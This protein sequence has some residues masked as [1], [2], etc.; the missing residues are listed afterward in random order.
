MS[1]YVGIVRSISVAAGM[2]AEHP[3]SRDRESVPAFGS[4]TEICELR[5]SSRWILVIKQAMHA[6]EPGCTNPSIIRQNPDS[7]YNAIQETIHQHKRN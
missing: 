4:I 6:R 3:V 5:T 7:T 1:S 2:E